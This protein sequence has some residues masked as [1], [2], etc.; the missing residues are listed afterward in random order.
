MTITVDGRPFGRST[1]TATNPVSLPGLFRRWFKRIQ[2]AR[3]RRAEHEIAMRFGLNEGRLTDD[4]ERRITAHI[5]QGSNF[6]L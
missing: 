2:V 6:R 5:L 1:S 4:L 3:M